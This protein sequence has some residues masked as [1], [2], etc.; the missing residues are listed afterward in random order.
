MPLQIE[1]SRLKR[2]LRAARVVHTDSECRVHIGTDGIRL[3]SF[4]RDRTIYLDYSLPHSVKSKCDDLDSAWI[5]LR[6]IKRIV[7]NGCIGE[8]RITLP[9]ETP[10]SAVIVES[11]GLVY[12]SQSL[13]APHGHNLPTPPDS[14]TVSSC[15]IRHLPFKRAVRMANWLGGE[16]EIQITPDAQRVAFTASHG[17]EDF[18]YVV[19]PDNIEAIHGSTTKLT[20]PIHV[21]RDFTPTLPTNSIIALRIK[22]HYLLLTVEFPIPDAELRLYI[23]ERKG[24]IP[25]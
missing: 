19:Q 16:V 6:P 8:V 21:L 2:I 23:A 1:A 4:R 5:K 18:T 13:T 15:S 10:D 3:Q 17:E 11:N 14:K 20:I 22:P 12:Q 25:G 7:D 24:I 9:F